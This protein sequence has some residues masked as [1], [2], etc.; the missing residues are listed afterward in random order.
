M[1]S[2]GVGPSTSYLNAV[3]FAPARNLWASKELNL[4]LPTYQIGVLPLNYSPQKAPTNFQIGV[5]TLSASG[6]T[7]LPAHLYYYCSIAARF[8][9]E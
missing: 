9:L 8:L 3:A 4:G 1:G 6:G 2:D 7:E 5:R